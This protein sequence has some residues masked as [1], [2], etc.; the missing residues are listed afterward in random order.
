MGTKTVFASIDPG[1]VHCGVAL[2]DKSKQLIR[3]FLA[4]GTKEQWLDFLE[5]LPKVT[6]GVM[7]VPQV[8]PGKAV[9]HEDLIQ[10]AASAGAIAGRMGGVWEQARPGIW[11]RQT[12]QD[13][14][15]RL[16]RA[17]NRLSANEK[18]RIE[19]PTNLKREA[20]VL[21]AIALGLW[22]LKRW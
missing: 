12:C 13:K 9:R 1:K 6:A 19:V 15:I 22:W 16:E 7:E 14:E 11:T 2:W 5:Q 8:Y 17:W 10:L 3:A 4:Q 21:D 20:D 18:E